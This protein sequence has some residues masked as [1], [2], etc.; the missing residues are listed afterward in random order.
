M[1]VSQTN[2]LW[3]VA[4]EEAPQPQGLKRAAMLRNESAQTDRDIYINTDESHP[5]IVVHKV[6]MTSPGFSEPNHK[7]RNELKSEPRPIKQEKP[8]RDRQQAHQQIFFDNQRPSSVPPPVVASNQILERA[9]Q[10]KP[11]GDWRAPAVS[12]F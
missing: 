10:K 8:R 2:A 3:L 9:Y 11:A 5:N 4:N 1:W 6:A 12:N 7:F